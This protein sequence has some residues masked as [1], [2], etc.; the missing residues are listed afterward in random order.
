MEEQRR[1]EEKERLRLAEMEKQKEQEYRKLLQAQASSAASQPTVRLSSLIYWYLWIM[2]SNVFYQKTRL[3]NGNLVAVGDEVAD[4]RPGRH[5][6]EQHGSS[7][8]CLL[9]G[10]PITIF[11]FFVQDHELLAW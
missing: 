3:V 1:K 2:F 10:T 11:T 7:R 9:M 8:L 6:P 4:S 5:A